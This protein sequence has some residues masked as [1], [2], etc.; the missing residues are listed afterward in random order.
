LFKVLYGVVPN[1]LI[2][3]FHRGRVDGPCSGCNHLRRLTSLASRCQFGPVGLGGRPS[4]FSAV[5]FRPRL[6]AVS[7]LMM[8]SMSA[9]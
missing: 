5:G 3:F 9:A 8:R 4:S 1:A 2:D 6:G 7:P